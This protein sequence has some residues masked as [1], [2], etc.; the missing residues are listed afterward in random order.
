MFHILKLFFCFLL[1]LSKQQTDIP[2]NYTVDM[3]GM[4][5]N[6]NRYPIQNKADHDLSQGNTGLNNYLCSRYLR[7]L[8]NYKQL[9][10]MS[11]YLHLGLSSNLPLRYLWKTACVGLRDSWS[12]SVVARYTS[13]CLTAA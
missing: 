5:R 11:K 1:C 10:E 9:N 2:S 3:S 6:L 4:I 8:L 12:G 13:V 7:Q